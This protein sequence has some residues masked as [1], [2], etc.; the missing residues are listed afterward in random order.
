MFIIALLLLVQLYTPSHTDLWWQTLFNTLHAP[1]FGLIAICSLFLT[2]ANWRWQKRLGVSFTIIIALSIVS[3]AAQI[4]LPN[5]AASTGDLIN[6]WVGAL[7]FLGIASA[8]SPGFSVPAGRGRYLVIGALLLMIW[9]L[10]PLFQVSVGYWERYRQLPSVVPLHSSHSRMFYD[11]HN[12]L[13]LYRQLPP[14]KRFATEVRFNSQGASSIKF[15]D[16]WSDWRS[17]EKLLIDVEN[18]G[19][20][21]LPLRIRI[22]DE[23]HRLGDQPHSDRFNRRLEITSGRNIIEIAL[24]DIKYAPV[25][26]ELNISRID[27]IVIFGTVSEAGRRFILY[28]IRLE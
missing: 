11:L 24:D 2:P 12:A 18:L 9:P 8:L 25:N 17:F 23:E 20:E 5:R 3:E 6:D 28:D 26:R 15:H 7:A 4:P 14:G 19:S 13:V 16:P 21:P 27:G 22:H 10:Q 1:V